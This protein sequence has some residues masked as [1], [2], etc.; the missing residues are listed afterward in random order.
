M[1]IVRHYAVSGEGPLD[2][3]KYDGGLFGIFRTVACI[4]DSLASGE[5]ESL[6]PDGKSGNHDYFEYSW[7]QFMAR[8]AGN[9]VYSFSRGGMTAHEYMDS[10]GDAMG[11]FDP[12]L[13][14]QAYIIALGVNDIVN[15]RIDLGSAADIDP[16]HPEN[17]PRTFAGN[18][19]RLISRYR[20][21]SPKG[22]FF[23]MSM[24]RTDV[25]DWTNDTVIDAAAD[26]LYDIAALFEYTYVMDFAR[27]APRHTKEFERHFYMGGHL[28]AAGYQLTAWQVMT[29]IDWLIRRYPE[30][31][32]QIAFV[33]RGGVHNAG[34]KW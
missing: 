27:C 1:N 29:Y 13:A 3:L 16:A 9:K 34:H 20:Q 23:L 5:M 7:G 6:M 17:N 12:A 24:V 19:G 4:G 22:R 10:F 21:I 11:Y 30:D 18:L 14:A 25:W 26:L 33:G 32:T 8:A 15:Q 2:E 31:F 28:N